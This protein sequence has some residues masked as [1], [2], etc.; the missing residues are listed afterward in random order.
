MLEGFI[1]KREQQEQ[2]AT[3]IERGEGPL[4]TNALWVCEE[5]AVRDALH[6][7][8]MSV[9]TCEC[10]CRYTCVCVCVCVCVC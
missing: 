9:C 3:V 8:V 6:Q 5:S 4:S 7:D 10:T 2:C 1:L